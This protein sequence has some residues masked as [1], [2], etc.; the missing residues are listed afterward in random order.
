MKADVLEMQIKKNE[1]GK[2]EMRR[3]FYA[4]PEDATADLDIVKKD[5]A[6]QAKVRS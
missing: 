5:L 6:Q 3:L 4:K 1:K 2:S